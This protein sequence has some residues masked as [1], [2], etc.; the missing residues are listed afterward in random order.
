MMKKK[1]VVGMLR[2]AVDSRCHLKVVLLYS[3][4]R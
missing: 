2:F 1:L 3:E 4:F